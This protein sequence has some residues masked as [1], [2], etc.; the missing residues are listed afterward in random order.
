MYISKTQRVFV[1]GRV[2]FACL[3]YTIPSMQINPSIPVEVR[4]IIQ[5]LKNKGFLAYIVGGCVRDILLEA[6]PKDWD[7][8]TNAT[9]DQIQ[10]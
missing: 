7:I 8:T 1:V 9:P 3:V 5:T 2:V 4:H 6:E 10:K